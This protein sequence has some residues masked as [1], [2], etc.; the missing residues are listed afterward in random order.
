MVSFTPSLLLSTQT[1][2]FFEYVTLLKGRERVLDRERER[3]RERDRERERIIEGKETLF[4]IK[5]SLNFL[6]LGVFNLNGDLQSKRLFQDILF[7]RDQ[8]PRGICRERERERD[9]ERAREKYLKRC[10]LV[11]HVEG[12]RLHIQSAK[13]LL[14][15][16]KYEI[17]LLPSNH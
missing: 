5:S 11:L 10:N 4:P 13:I 2:L 17:I 9:R 15:P 6:F 7:L 3:E 14:L 8:A 1:F 16:S 12:S